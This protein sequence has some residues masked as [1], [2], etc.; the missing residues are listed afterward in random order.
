M[1]LG[2]SYNTSAY[3]SCRLGPQSFLRA[4]WCP[5]LTLQHYLPRS[6]VPAAA[7]LLLWRASCSCLLPAGR[8]LSLELSS[9]TETS[10]SWKRAG[11]VLHTA[12]AVWAPKFFLPLAFSDLS[13]P[14]K[15]FTWTAA[16]R[17]ASTR[18]HLKLLGVCKQIGT[19]QQRNKKMRGAKVYHCF[20]Y[21]M[22]QWDQYNT[23]FCYQTC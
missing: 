10:C 9:P 7:G 4:T 16:R 19:S 23:L 22:I 17:S 2:A 5:R 11:I 15:H 20:L 21:I 1:Q 12:P 3:C 8:L 14:F 18:A 6:K 13:C